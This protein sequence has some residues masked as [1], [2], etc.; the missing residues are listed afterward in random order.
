MIKKE[1]TIQI[2]PMQEEGPK[3]PRSIHTSTPI[4]SQV[5]LYPFAPFFRSEHVRNVHNGLAG[6]PWAK[7]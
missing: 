7:P 5:L 6:E 2:G 3:S 4:I 1:Q